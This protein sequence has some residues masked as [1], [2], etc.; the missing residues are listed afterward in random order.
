MN[1]N[2]FHCV[3]SQSL[4]QPLHRRQQSLFCSPLDFS[5]RF[6]HFQILRSISTSN[7]N[8]QSTWKVKKTFQNETFYR[9]INLLRISLQESSI[10]QFLLSN[11]FDVLLPPLT[12]N[13]TV[14][15]WSFCRRQRRNSRRLASSRDSVMRNSSSFRLSGFDVVTWHRSSCFTWRSVRQSVMRIWLTIAALRWMVSF[16]IPLIVLSI[17]VRFLSLRWSA[18]IE[19]LLELFRFISGLHLN[20]VYQFRSS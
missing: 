17:R 20:P 4:Q 12:N 1:A 5:N 15:F 14:E 18:E 19:F 10:K 16:A 6:H 7:F 2:Q 8:S 9:K 11:D 13:F 3:V